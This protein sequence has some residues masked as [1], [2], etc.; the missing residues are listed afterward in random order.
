VM[1]AI[2]MHV[3]NVGLSYTHLK[4]LLGNIGVI[5]TIVPYKVWGGGGTVED[6]GFTNKLNIT[7]LR[8]DI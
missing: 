8:S 5:Q 4:A 7:P 3:A 2:H 6:R 1:C